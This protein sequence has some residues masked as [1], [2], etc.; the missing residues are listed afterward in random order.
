MWRVY[1]ATVLAWI[2][3]V[4]PLFT[5]GA[6]TAEFDA[7]AARIEADMPRIR[8]YDAA[9]KYWGERH[10]PVAARW[11]S[12]HQLAGVGHGERW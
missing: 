10:Q 4:P 8:T 6:C 1:A 12:C 5:D 2:L 11:E 7:E 3:L 9:M